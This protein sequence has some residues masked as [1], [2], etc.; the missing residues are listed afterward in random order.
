MHFITRSSSPTPIPS[1]V[2]KYFFFFFPRWEK[3][4]YPV[5]STAHSIKDKTELV[6][7]FVPQSQS[8]Y[9]SPAWGEWV[10]LL[11]GKSL[12]IA[13][14]YAQCMI[15]RERQEESIIEKI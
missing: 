2:E 5:K 3:N 7:S 13:R 6:E 11:V 8:G 10:I 4:K 15:Q 1:K 14:G 9:G 12:K